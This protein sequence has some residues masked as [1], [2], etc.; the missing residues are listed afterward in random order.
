MSKEEWQRLYGKCSGNEIYHIR[1]GDSKIF[2]EY[3]S[4]SFTYASFHS[5]RKYGVC[6]VGVRPA[7]LPEFYEDTILLNPGPRHIMKKT[8]LCFYLSITKEEHLAF[9]TGTSN[10]IATAAGNAATNPPAQES[11]VTTS[12]NKTHSETV[13]KKETGV[14][15]EENPVYRDSNAS[16]TSTSNEKRQMTIENAMILYTAREELSPAIHIEV[17]NVSM[18]GDRK[19]SCVASPVNPNMNL[20]ML[21][22]TSDQRSSM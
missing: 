2:G 13:Q 6:L 5:H 11:V 7:Q 21:P 14:H 22:S 19:S 17:D 12:A 20:L 3:E 10:N 1:L 9:V 15:D 4:K 18:G 8:D 16:T